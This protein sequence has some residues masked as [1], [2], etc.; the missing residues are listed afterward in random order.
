MRPSCEVSSSVEFFIKESKRV[1]RASPP[2]PLHMER[3][4]FDCN[5]SPD[6][7]EFT[8]VCALSIV[9]ESRKKNAMV[10]VFFIFR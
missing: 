2:A 9:A 3:G 4:E 7:C 1:E 5:V 8:S 10:M 6:N